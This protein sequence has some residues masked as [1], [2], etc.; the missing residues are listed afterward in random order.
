MLASAAI[1]SGA[2]PASAALLTTGPCP[3][4]GND[5]NGCALVITLNP[6]GTATVSNGP[7]HGVP[8]DGSD[9]T[10]VGVINNSGVT[11]SSITIQS[12]LDIF[13]FDGDGAGENPN[14]T[15]GKAGAWQAYG[16][17]TPAGENTLA[18]HGP[19]YSGTDSTSADF[20]LSGQLNSFANITGVD[21]PGQVV[22]GTGLVAGGTAWFSLEEAL[23]AASFTIPNVGGVPEPTTLS[24]LGVGLAGLG[25]AR[26]RRKLG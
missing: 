14:S 9:D 13:G 24:I 21:G 12:N 8:F 6:N 17:S 10:L 2:T 15:S 3:G 16:L 4:F 23:N 19:T 1:F 20:D 26:R 5:P 25:L 22:F 7:E 11:V 18:A